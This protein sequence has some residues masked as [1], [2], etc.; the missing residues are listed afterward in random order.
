MQ[1]VLNQV[2]SLWKPPTELL[3]SEWADKYRYLSPESSAISGKYRTDYAP[4]QKEIMD[5]FNDPK[6]ERIVWMKSAQV[7]ATEILNNVVGYTIHLQPS[8]VLIMQP[9]LQMAQ[10]YSKEKLANMLRDTPVL[11]E[12]MNEP[13]SKTSS[14][15]VLSKKFTGG[16][17]LNM[18]GSNSAASLASRSIRLL[19]VDEVDRMEALSLIHI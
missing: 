16:T 5:V 2:Q 4:Y 15:T 8:P 18:S 11:R 1:N 14:N 12:R 6:I 9:T 7:G 10:A 19:C 13:K 17:T 3:I